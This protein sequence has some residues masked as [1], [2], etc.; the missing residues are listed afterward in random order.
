MAFAVGKIELKE[1]KK[2]YG[3]KRPRKGRAGKLI[4]RTRRVRKSPHQPN[5]RKLETEAILERIVLRRGELCDEVSKLKAILANSTDQVDR[6]MAEARKKG[7]AAE[8]C[9]LSK[10]A[11]KTRKVLNG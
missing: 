1:K 5:P 4:R 3:W 7:I 11:A 9:E 6:A 10:Q 2:R 8:R